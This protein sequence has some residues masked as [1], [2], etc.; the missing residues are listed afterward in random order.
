MI[1]SEGLSR[2]GARVATRFKQVA[3]GQRQKLVQ[4]ARKEG[5][6]A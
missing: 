2:P 6:R 1:S 3:T 4:L 5:V